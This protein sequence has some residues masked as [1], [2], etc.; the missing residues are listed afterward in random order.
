[1]NELAVGWASELVRA[2]AALAASA[3]VVAGAMRLLKIASPRAWRAAYCLVLVQG[4]LVVHPRI[5]L[6][7]GE[8]QPAESGSVVAAREPQAREQT[9]T[10]APREVAA[11]EPHKEWLSSSAA[12]GDE[13]I[14]PQAATIPEHV[15]PQTAKAPLGGGWL[16][17]IATSLLVVWAAGIL[18]AAAALAMSY[19]R[20]LREIGVSR[21][22]APEWLD[23][24]RLAL[25]EHGGMRR[26]ELL[27]T[28]NFGPLVCWTPQGRRVLV[29]ENL[30]RE[31]NAVQRLAVLR[32]ELAHCRRGDLW[33][34]LAVRLLA[35]PHWFNPFAWQAVRK[36]D[37][38]AEWACD[39]LAQRT[40][41]DRLEYAKALLRLCHCRA[42]RRSLAAAA[43]GRRVAAR[44]QRILSPQHDVESLLRKSALVMCAAA[45][46]L[47][48]WVRI[49]LVARAAEPSDVAAAADDDASPDG[50]PKPN[51][52]ANAAA[53]DAQADD[54][55]AAERKAPTEID[56]S[57]LEMLARRE[58][59][60]AAC[61]V[62]YVMT[63]D[64][65]DAATAKEKRIE[66]ARDGASGRW[67]QKENEFKGGVRTQQYEF[68]VEQ[69]GKRAISVS[70]HNWNGLNPPQVHIDQP[71]PE[72]RREYDATPLYGLFPQNVPLSSMLKEQEVRVEIV[73]GDVRLEWTRQVD[74]FALRYDVR[75]STEHDFTP[76]EVNYALNGDAVSHWR[77]AQL[78]QVDGVW[79]AV[80]G[81]FFNRPRR[82]A[83]KT[84]R[85]ELGK[86]LPEAAMRYEIPDGAWVID[87][88]S[89]RQ[90]TQGRV[91]TKR[92]KPLKVVVR[93]VANQP[94]AGATVKVQLNQSSR[95]EA[96]KEALEIQTDAEGL[97]NFEA[98][99]DNVLHLQASKGGMRPSSIILGDGQELTMYL[100]PHTSGTVVDAQG[101]PL[102]NAFVHTV[103]QGFEMAHGAIKSVPTA[104]RDT[105]AVGA[106]GSYDF[107]Q[108][109]TLRRLSDPLMFVAYADDGRLMAIR[110]VMPPELARPLDFVLQPAA[111]VAAEFELPP[112]APAT[113]QIGALWTDYEG[114]RIA[115]SQTEMRSE[116]AADAH[117]AKMIGR[118]PPGKY[119]LHVDAT[120]ET[121]SAV[122]DFIV[123]PKQTEVS[124]GIIPLRPSKFA[125]LRGQVAPELSAT[126]MPPSELKPLSELRGQLVV[127]N[128]WHWLGE[129]H[130]DHPEQTPF[131]TL[132]AR[133]KDQPVYWIAIHHHRVLDPDALATKVASMRK[134]LWGEGPAP[135]ASLIDQSEPA[136]PVEGAP[137]RTA[138]EAG[139][140]GPTRDVTHTRYGIAYRPLVLIDRQGRVVGCYDE[141]ELEPALKRLLEANE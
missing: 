58:A 113:T 126:P 122:I 11:A 40:E 7:W 96:G 22:L 136:P 21:P 87:D 24:W 86:P 65:G 77:A 1:M 107:T 83:F 49:D 16:A 138:V 140:P 67:F 79:Y 111:Q 98:V 118:L 68:Y 60:F 117:Q 103:T 34:S 109:L 108:D 134:A 81:E 14:P 75:L 54:A 6:P 76:V 82:Y 115:Y 30:W 31:L 100:T 47:V 27:V 51:A 72:S 130:N 93:D 41:E 132:P 23:E 15:R 36:F 131:F 37:E 97:A 74:N 101:R 110:T 32:H 66:F 139:V 114:R 28:A 4:W 69:H 59:K 64:K 56:A 33:K 121:E 91:E 123:R 129:K 133:Y 128:F 42:S 9:A 135:F 78:K 63:E 95:D 88:V 141:A 102:Q 8:P 39:A 25:A 13:L 106:D 90:Y 17:T 50:R 71:R 12:E 104:Q 125:M 48:A 137:A 116:A 92:T 57:F 94:I 85:F 73:A 61:R 120:A 124:L 53:K 55:P 127:L 52:P 46:L 62:E 10:P 20:F 44:L 80:E 119:Q 84:T 105:A 45:L 18:A 3:M 26:M 112:G 35:A 5:E 38:A 70:Q 43:G 99:P 29:P 2:T 89:G 19:W